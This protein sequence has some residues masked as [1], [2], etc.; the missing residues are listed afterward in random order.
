MKGLEA[1][2][3]AELKTDPAPVLQSIRE[4]SQKIKHTGAGLV[5]DSPSLG[6]LELC[7]H[8][9]AAYNVISPLQEDGGDIVGLL[10]RAMMK[11]I[12]TWSMRLAL[13]FMLYTCKG[14][15]D[16]LRDIFGRLMEQYG[17]TFKWTSTHREDDDADRFSLEI[18]RCFYYEFFK[19]HDKKMLTPV[20]CRLDSLWFEM[21]DPQKH[22]F[23][24]DKSRYQTQGYGAPVCVFPIVMKKKDH[25]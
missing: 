6:H 25:S 4:E 7:S 19:S 9:L 16:R 12:N 2:I 20:L 5:K 22:G 17:A 14:N 13:R 24:F 21:V 8:L 18:Q 23:Y 1:E 3:K 11:G 15:P 10:N